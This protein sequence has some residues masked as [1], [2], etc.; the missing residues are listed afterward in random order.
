[1]EDPIRPMLPAASTLQE[2]PARS[3]QIPNAAGM[4]SLGA[5]A[6]AAVASPETGAAVGF[7]MLTGAA[8][9]ATKAA[10]TAVKTARRAKREMEK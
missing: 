8:S 6:P 2:L 10:E 3:V 4:S 7:A 1:M 9:C 5:L